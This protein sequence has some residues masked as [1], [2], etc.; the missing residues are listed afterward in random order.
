[1]SRGQRVCVVV[2]LGA[3]LTVVATAVTGLIVAPP[4]TGDWFMY[5]S[6]NTTTPF[7]PAQDRGHIALM[8]IVWLIA[9]GAW[10]F[11]AWRMFRARSSDP[12]ASTG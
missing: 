9:V 6:D 10:L 1:M 5:S 4:E 11:V 12:S 3:A 7:T 2:A 8:A